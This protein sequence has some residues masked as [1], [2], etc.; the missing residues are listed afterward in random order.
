MSDETLLNALAS[1]EHARVLV[2]GDV[3]LDRFVYGS[4]ER[5][6]PEAPVPVLALGRTS[7]M[8]GGAANVARN[9]VA[10]GARVQLLGVVGED[11]TGAQLRTH[12][13][14]LANLQ[15]QLV[16][17]AGRPTT[18]KTRYVADRQ[19]ILRTDLENCGPLAAA[20]AE[21]VLARFRAAL[22][23]T[24]VVILSDYNKGVLNAAVTA[25]AIAAARSAGKPVLVD[26]KGRSFEKYRGAT[27]L[28]PNKQELQGACGHDCTSDEQVIEAARSVLAQGICSTVV[29]TRGKEGMTIVQ[30]DGRAQHIRTVATEVYDVTGAG[31]TAVAAMAVSLAAGADISAAAR[32]ANIAAGIAVGK[33]GTA[34]AS[35]DEILERLRSADDGGTAESNYTLERARLLAAHWRRLG[36]KVAFTNGCFD[37]LHPGHV[38]LL[39]Q[40]RHTADRLVVGLNSDASVRRLKGAG[41]PVQGAGAR[42]LVLAS[43]RHV[44]A[45]VIFE[46]DTPL[47]LI[48][49]LE[50]DV[51][52]KGADYTVDQVVGADLV[53]KRGGRVV[54]AELL[55]AHSTTE[56]I[57][58]M[59]A[60]GKA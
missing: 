1:F 5:T 50:P 14:A 23:D 4:V 20:V 25:A 13:A 52:V 10:L 60:G 39:T 34:T 22:A 29:A 19:Q 9:V 28:T 2:L 44:D 7:D 45:V 17:D 42:A 27:V 24:D 18:T 35:G 6:S 37:M 16:A 54:L 30:A 57:R 12:L 38:S 26:P 36:L 43:L 15:A 59:T 8:P 49:A 53:L 40:A 21:A 55:P 11:A 56:T 33:Y 48:Q 51:L 46:E 31:D 58:R 47:G 32:L 3:M 41:R